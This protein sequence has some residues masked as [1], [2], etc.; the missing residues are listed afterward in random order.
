MPRKPRTL[1]T[2]EDWIKVSLQ[3]NMSLSV[4]MGG[5]TGI[6]DGIAGIVIIVVVAVLQ[7]EDDM[8]TIV[9]DRVVHHE[10]GMTIIVA[11]GDVI[12]VL[13]GIAMMI[14]VADEVALG[15]LSSGTEVVPHPREGI[16]EVMRTIA[17][18]IGTIVMQDVVG[19]TNGN[20]EMLEAINKYQNLSELVCLSV[21]G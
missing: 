10:T 20:T 1:P 17:G 14:T 8:M 5:I 9:V 6:V 13:Q 18:T 19:A 16:G 3:W 4:R 11:E 21:V 2:V 15:A 12:V 7:G